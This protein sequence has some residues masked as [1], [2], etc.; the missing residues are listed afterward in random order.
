MPQKNTRNLNASKKTNMSKKAR[1]SV[2]L[3]DHARAK[4]KQKLELPAM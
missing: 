3:K 4:L 1:E 2:Q